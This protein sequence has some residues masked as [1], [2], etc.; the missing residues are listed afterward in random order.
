MKQ[1]LILELLQI[2]LKT[3]ITKKILTAK[4]LVTIKD[5]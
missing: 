3:A 4:I 2:S 1:T 5:L